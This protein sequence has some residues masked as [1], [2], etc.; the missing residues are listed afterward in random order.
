MMYLFRLYHIAYGGNVYPSRQTIANALRVHPNT[1]DK[2]NRIL[3]ALGFLSWL[4][5]KPNFTSNTYFID[6]CTQNQTMIRPE[7]FVIPRKLWFSLRGLMNKLDW[8]AKQ[9]LYTTL[10]KDFVNHILTNREYL[11]TLLKESMQ[12]SFEKTKDPPKKKKRPF[13]WNL[14]KPFKLPF[15][16]NIILSG[17]GEATLRASIEDYHAY[18]GWKK[19]I[20]NPV[21]F[22]IARCKFYK[23][24]YHNVE[25][26]TP[27]QNLTWVKS[28]LKNNGAEFVSSEIEIPRDSKKLFTKLMICKKQ[29]EKSVLYL[30]KKI[31]GYWIDKRITLDN[32]RLVELVMPFFG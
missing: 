28:Q 15:K 23:A 16:E 3:K 17:F 4:S 30:W 12:K 5:G 32:P 6:A 27:K 7:G 11:R 25:K 8:E 10:I 1:V 13:L 26:A 21:A 2:Y 31:N 24:K 19:S 14:L 9:K 29:K 20:D 22:L 18:L